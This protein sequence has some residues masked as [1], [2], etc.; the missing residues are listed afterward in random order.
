MELLQL[1]NL[2]ID[3]CGSNSA[4]YTALHRAAQNGHLDIVKVL[5][6]HGASIDIAAVFSDDLA[7][8]DDDNLDSDDLRSGGLNHATPLHLAVAKGHITVTKYLIAKG[9]DINKLLKDGSTALHL[10]SRQSVLMLECLLQS[11]GQRFSLDAKTASGKTVLMEAAYRGIPEVLQYVLDNSSSSTITSENDNGE[12]CLHYAALSNHHSAPKVITILKGYNLDPSLKTH[13]RCSLKPEFNMSGLTPLHLA[14]RFGT[15]EAFE[16]ILSVTEELSN[17]CAALQ[18]P[19]TCKILPSRTFLQDP[20]GKWCHAVNG[21]CMINCVTDTEESALHLCINFATGLVS[22]Q[23]FALLLSKP[24]IELEFLDRLGRSPLLALCY[25]MT[26]SHGNVKDLNLGLAA[27]ILIKRGADIAA[28][29]NNG[30][31]ALHCLATS[32]LI[33]KAGFNAIFCILNREVQLP[34][35]FGQ[36]LN[37]LISMW[38]FEIRD[39][40]L[41][42]GY[43]KHYPPYKVTS[44][45]SLKNSCRFGPDIFSLTNHDQ[46]NALQIFFA[47]PEWKGT[48]SPLP[49]HTIQIALLLIECCPRTQINTFMPDGR[50]FLNIS[51]IARAAVLSKRL[52]ELGA[53]LTMR[54]KTLLANSPLDLI[55]QCGCPDDFVIGSI[56]NAEKNQLGMANPCTSTAIHAACLHKNASIVKHLLSAGWNTRTKDEDGFEPILAA[57]SCGD[58]SIVEILLEHHAPTP[59][60]L[61]GYRYETLLLGNA[62][63]IAICNLLETNGCKDW[64]RV[65]SRSVFAGPWVDGISTGQREL[66][67]WRTRSLEGITAL[68]LLAYHGFTDGVEYSLERGKDVDV[69]KKIEFNLTPLFFAIFGRRANAVQFLLAHGSRMDETYQPCG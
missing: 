21:A 66:E 33:S 55:C 68:H 12:N 45:S 20:C 19:F 7:M 29:D 64:G 34:P 26:Y 57:V 35:T 38:T 50:R 8:L 63:S 31:T 60:L 32:T 40:G 52:V 51:I 23:K 6:E 17:T 36:Q 22:L 61:H 44:S 3:S 39:F 27:Y 28:R 46:H 11:P 18:I 43:D 2:T 47:R 69:N 49:P 4:G 9:A 1:P 37:D 56:I 53:D 24:S 25:C 58:V 48:K 30:N 15:F 16:A 62:S 14:A 67:L 5:L 54:D 13:G 59:E 10:A 42:F 65:L 41:D